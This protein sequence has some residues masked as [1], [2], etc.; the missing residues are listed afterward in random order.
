MH[1]YVRVKHSAFTRMARSESVEAT[2]FAKPL[3]KLRIVLD[4]NGLF[5][6]TDLQGV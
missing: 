1:A 2:L 5:Y 4:E 6:N 3:D